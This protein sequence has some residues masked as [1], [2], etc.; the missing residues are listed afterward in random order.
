MNIVVK[1]FSRSNAA[2]RLT[3]G[4]VEHDK[5]VAINDVRKAPNFSEFAS[6]QVSGKFGTPS[7]TEEY[8]IEP[9][10]QSFALAIQKWEGI[11]T[12]RPEK[13]WEVIHGA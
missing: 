10:R 8:E 4:K 6:R 3:Y 13:V 11:S 9:E 1:P 12:S 7:Y 2:I 5:F